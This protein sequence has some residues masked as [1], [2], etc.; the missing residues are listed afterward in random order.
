MN[1]DVDV[2]VDVDVNVV[3]VVNGS[4]VNVNVPRKSPLSFPTIHLAQRHLREHRD[5]PLQQLARF[6]EL[7]GGDETQRFERIDDRGAFQRRASRNRIESA[8][9]SLRLAAALRDVER[10]GKRRSTQL[11]SQFPMPARGSRCQRAAES[12]E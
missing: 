10:N 5:R 7:L 4:F 1:V 12:E 9:I 6:H 2:D 3:V 8:R 11:V